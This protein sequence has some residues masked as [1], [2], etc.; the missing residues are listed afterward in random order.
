[1][2]ATSVTHAVNSGGVIAKD[3]EPMLV[4]EYMEHKS[5]YELLQN[6]TFELDGSILLNILRAMETIINERSKNS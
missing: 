4:M 6:R 1:M 2:R 5:L 3:V